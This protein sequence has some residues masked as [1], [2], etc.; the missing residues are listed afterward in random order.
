MAISFH[1]GR[2]GFIG[3]LK[4]LTDAEGNPRNGVIPAFTQVDSTGAEASAG[5]STSPLFT[6]GSRAFVVKSAANIPNSTAAYSSGKVIGG[7][8][9]IATGLPAGT[10]ITVGNFVIRCL[11]ADLTTAGAVNYYFSDAALTALADNATATL[12]AADRDKI[13]K[14]AATSWVTG[15]TGSVSTLTP[16]LPRLTVDV[17]GNIHLLLVASAAVLFANATCLSWELDGSY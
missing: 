17:N 10:I 6:S 4:S 5:T 8:L 13:V 7:N 11:A 15:T 2:R 14:F 1:T 16:V 12:A 3:F 9:A